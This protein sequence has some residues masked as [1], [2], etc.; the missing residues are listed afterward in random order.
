[1]K[2]KINKKKKLHQ[3]MKSDRR[4]SS[5]LLSHFIS[6]LKIRK[7]ACKK[8]NRNKCEGCR[9]EVHEYS[10]EF[11]LIVNQSKNAGDKNRRKESI[12]TEKR[13]F[14]SCSRQYPSSAPVFAILDER[15]TCIDV[16]GLISYQQLLQ[17]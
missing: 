13:P 14:W 12:T 4:V 16:H 1:M 7:H 3:G 15:R 11:I 17:R 6:F 10:S 9:D 5:G 8:Q 2:N